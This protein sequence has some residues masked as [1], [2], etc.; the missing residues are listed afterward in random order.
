MQSTYIIEGAF[1]LMF[2]CQKWTVSREKWTVS[3]KKWTASSKKWTVSSK[4]WTVSSKKWTV[5][6]KKWPKTS[7]FT[8]FSIKRMFDKVDPFQNLISYVRQNRAT[9]CSFHFQYLISYVLQRRVTFCLF[10]QFSSCNG[11]WFIMLKIFSVYD[12]F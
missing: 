12:I 9:F 6:K 2:E 1:N 5:F 11:F 8:S 10:F 3:R 4:K 7:I